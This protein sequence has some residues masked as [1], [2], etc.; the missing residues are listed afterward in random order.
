MERL[1][2]AAD[3]L[4]ATLRRAAAETG[5]EFVDVL[6]GFLGHAVCDTTEWLNG[7]AWPIEGSYHPNHLGHARYARAVVARLTEPGRETALEAMRAEGEPAVVRRP[8]PAGPAPTFSLPDLMSGRARAMA[9]AHGIPEEERQRLA[10]E[11]RKHDP[12]PHP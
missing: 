3:E 12:R 10:A 4:S 1:N 8:M 11:I 6:P 7:V 2:A 5:C 9:A